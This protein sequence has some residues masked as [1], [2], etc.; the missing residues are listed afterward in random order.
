MATR[1]D[2]AAKKFARFVK[3][4]AIRA[5][6]AVNSSSG[7]GKARLAKEA[8]MSEADI[9]KILKGEFEIPADPLK[10]LATAL[11]VPQKDLLRAAG[12]LEEG[13]T[14]PQNR[15]L[16]VQLAAQRLGIKSQKNVAAFEALVSV[17]L[18]AEKRR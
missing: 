14:P 18:D 10:S 1:P 13:S 8:D 9:S 6:Y 11:D 16:T 4:A 2:P 15:P 5:G 12:V 7:D 3:D 17:L